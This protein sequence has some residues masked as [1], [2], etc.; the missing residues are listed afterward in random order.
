[1]RLMRAA[2]VAYAVL[3]YRSGSQSGYFKNLGLAV[4][5]EWVQRLLM[6]LECEFDGVTPSLEVCMDKASLANRHAPAV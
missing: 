3:R 4:E 6:R 2:I 5:K 1:M